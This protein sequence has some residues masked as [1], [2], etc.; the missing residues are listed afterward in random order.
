[1]TRITRK[2]PVVTR[3]AFCHTLVAKVDRSGP[4]RE[5]DDL[6][7]PHVCDLLASKRYRSTVARMTDLVEQ[8]LN[9]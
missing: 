5:L 4:P 2:H 7:S 6:A 8:A 1:M 9:E 3:C